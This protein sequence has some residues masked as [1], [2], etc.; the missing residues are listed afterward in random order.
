MKIALEVFPSY[1]SCLFPFVFILQYIMLHYLAD[2]S[3][4]Q[5]CCPLIDLRQAAAGKGRDARRH[6][7]T[8]HHQTGARTD[9]NRAHQGAQVQVSANTITVICLVP[10]AVSFS[11]LQCEIFI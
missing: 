11:F 6:G 2:L 3:D 1:E 5:C 4:Q 7:R 10:D 9:A 8:R